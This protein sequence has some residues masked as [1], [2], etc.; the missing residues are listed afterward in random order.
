MK[1][2]DK[3][4]TDPSKPWFTN[5]P[6]ERNN[7]NCM[8]KEMCQ[9]AGISGTLTNHSSH[10]CG[11]TT[12]FSAGTS[13]KLVQEQTGHWSS[14]VS[15]QYKHSLEQVDSLLSKSQVLIS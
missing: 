10:A 15:H 13:Q 9:Q 1:P 11:A 4:T 3:V 12:M 2:L 6:V 5:V 14:K 7:L 8:L